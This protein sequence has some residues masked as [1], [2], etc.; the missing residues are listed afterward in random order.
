MCLVISS[1]LSSN[2]HMLKEFVVAYKVNTFD[3]LPAMFQVH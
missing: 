2:L 3:L 1:A